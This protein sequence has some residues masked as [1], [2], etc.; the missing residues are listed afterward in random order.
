MVWDAE[1][2]DVIV[3]ACQAD[4]FKLKMDGNQTKTRMNQTRCHKHSFFFFYDPAI[5]CG[6]QDVWKG[7]NVRPSVMDGLCQA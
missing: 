2:M 6:A 5:L 7:E 1:K 4:L 3:T